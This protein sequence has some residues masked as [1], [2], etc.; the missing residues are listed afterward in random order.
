MIEE[1]EKYIR[2]LPETLQE[3]AR[4]IKTK[5]EMHAFIADNGLE[6]PEEALKLVSGGCGSA[7]EVC[8]QCGSTNI[9]HETSMGSDLKVYCR[10]CGCILFMQPLR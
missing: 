3:K 2:E 10:N 9:V 4:G 5:E 8:P 1:F 7:Q 6:L